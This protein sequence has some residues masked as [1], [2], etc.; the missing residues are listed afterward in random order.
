MTKLFGVPLGPLAAVM[1]AIVAVALGVLAAFALRN[2]ILL[3]LGTRNVGRRR[4]R[5]ALIIVGLMLGTTIIASALAT[6][7]TMSHT[8]RAAAVKSLGYTDEVIGAKG[9]KPTLAVTDAGAATGVAYFPAIYSLPVSAAVSSSRLVDGVTPAIIEP[10]ATLDTKTRQNEPQMTLFATDPADMRGFGVIRTRDGRGVSL[11]QLHPGEVFINIKAAEQ[12]DAHTGDTVLV[13]AGRSRMPARVAAIVAY[14]GTGTSKSAVLLPLGAAQHLLGKPGQVNKILV[15]NHGAEL[16]GST[17]SDQVVAKLRPTL[18][19]LGLDVST[20]KQDAI[21]DADTAGAAFMS[22]F[23]TF[24][25]FSIAAGILLIFLIFVMLAAERRGELGIARAVGTRRSHIVQMFVFEGMAYDL[26]AAAVGAL[27][28]IAV[29]YGMVVM[30]SSTFATTSDLQV[31]YAVKPASL[32]IAYTIGVLL[33]FGVVAFSAWRVSRMNIV[34]AIRNLPEP[35]VEKGRKRRSALAAAGIVLGVVL[36]ISGANSKTATPF[37][38]GVSLLILSLVPMARLAGIRERPART[39]AGLALVLWWVL[40]TTRWLLGQ[41]SSD[42]SIAILSGLM[43]VIGASW[44]I[45][46]NADA[47]LGVLNATLGRNRRLAPILKMSMA[48]PLRSLFRTGVTFAMFTL[49]VFTLVIGATAT[50]AFTNAFNDMRSF[51]GGFDIRA[52]TAPASPIPDMSTALRNAAGLNSADFRYVSTQSFLPV[53]A[54]QVGPG[55]QSADYVVR[56]LDP[57]FLEHTTY[58]MAS[59]ANGYSSARQVW[60]AVRLHRRLAV[61]DASIAPRLGGFSFG[62]PPEFKLTGFHLEDRHF[63]PFQIDSRDPQTGRSIRVTVIGVLSETAPFSM[64]G[65]STSQQ[66]LIPIFGNRVQPSVY[67]FA[68]KPGVDATNMAKT[69]QSAFLANGMHADAMSKLLSDAVGAN[70]TI[71][72]LIEGFMGL[73]LIVGVAA[74]GV[75][76]ARAVVER[77]QQI[78]VLRAI[79][80]QRRMV[81]ASFLLESS[82]I[83]LSSILVGTLLGLAIAY[84][85]IYD[86]Q[87][88]PSWSNITFSPPWLMLGIIFL[89][90]YAIALATSYMPA[91]RASRVYPAEALRY[92]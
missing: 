51:G 68:L 6:G 52:T 3:R 29:A 11:A 40:P 85:M 1:V 56:G 38:L 12:L 60:Q 58:G 72:L 10:V 73:G 53:K 61:I 76:S 84:N 91:R 50:D 70:R 79:G 65:I 7:D 16:S 41:T 36:A 9:A 66:Q 26:I 28:G 45:M 23:T 34:T 80:F 37:N 8:I 71:N 89:A 35:P 49:V 64:A 31:S 32:V 39:I 90:V 17:Q 4:G 47:L 44:T 67:L 27:V 15:S 75:I 55:H 82:F 19:R 33:T 57:V 74:L 62:P 30:M 81:Q 21:K 5:S 63:K 54:R 48:Y 22:L 87:H 43:V 25:S 69:L 18:A 14:D 46:Y 77:R 78:G 83:A 13:L 92:Q 59:M 86:A 20:A 42:F 2:R 24:G 88:Q